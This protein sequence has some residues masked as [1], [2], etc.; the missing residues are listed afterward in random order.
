M[1]LA[2]AVRDGRPEL[3]AAVG[4]ESCEETRAHEVVLYRSELG[5]SGARYTALDR[6]PLGGSPEQGG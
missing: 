4:L 6:F 1:T 3:P 2:R 5:S